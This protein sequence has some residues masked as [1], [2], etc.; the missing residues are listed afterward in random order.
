MGQVEFLFYN[1]TAQIPVVGLCRLGSPF[2]LQLGSWDPRGMGL[3]CLR[4]AKGIS[5][6]AGESLLLLL[7]MLGTITCA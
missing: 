7:R 5:G 4:I 1:S 3:S 6:S 2:N